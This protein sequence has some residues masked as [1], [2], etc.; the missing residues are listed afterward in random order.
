MTHDGGTH[1]RQD[2]D[3]KNGHRKW[4][5]VGYIIITCV[6]IFG[7]ALFTI[8]MHGNGDK[9]PNNT[10][11]GSIEVSGMTR[12]QANDTIRKSIDGTTAEFRNG[13][14]NAS[15]HY[16]DIGAS[17]D[18]PSA[19]D[20][21][22][23]PRSFIAGMMNTNVS[24]PVTIDNS[25]ARKT[26]NEKLLIGKDTVTDERLSFD[27]GAYTI[28]QGTTGKS[29]DMSVVDN[30]I[31]GTSCTRICTGEYDGTASHKTINATVITE[32]P[33]ALNNADDIIKTA[34]AIIGRN[35]MLNIDGDEVVIP[36]SVAA[37]WITT[38]SNNGKDTV[39]PDVEGINSSMNEYLDSLGTPAKNETI[40]TT[41]EGGDIATTSY[42]IDGEKIV[43]EDGMASKIASSITQ[44]KDISIQAN[45]VTVDFAQQRTK[46]PSDFGS[47]N[48]SHWLKI[49]L[50]AQTVYAYKGTTLVNT[51][52]L[53][54]GSAGSDA[55]DAGTYYINVKYTLQTMRGVGYVSPDVPWVSYFNGGEGFH[56]APWNTYNITHGIP[57]SHGCAN[58][59]VNDAKWIYDFAPLGTK[60]EVVGTTPTGSV[61]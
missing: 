31:M 35:Y 27:N 60:V 45:R 59:F 30:A 15:L 7:A 28:R 24:I 4:M 20:K 17:F 25:V 8:P 36:K 9:I 57:S 22:M 10:T 38:S 12:K 34:N 29:V 50:N 2:T 42:G 61:R 14:R 41:P 1:I 5:I 11:I 16:S 32:K 52:P 55:T 19:I 58:M 53:A 33:Y 46:A 3:T 37:H 40:I 26:L 48:G 47:A 49:D 6:A 56:G 13:S 39:T 18:I 23:K 54:T 43:A 51:L 44:G 21:A